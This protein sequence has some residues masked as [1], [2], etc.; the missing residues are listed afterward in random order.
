MS[1]NIATARYTTSH[2]VW[3]VAFR[4]NGMRHIPLRHTCGIRQSQRLTYTPQAYLWNT[5]INSSVV[6]TPWNW[7]CVYTLGEGIVTY[8]G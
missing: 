7:T 8:A 5:I 3:N 2:P 1:T 6:D 4:I